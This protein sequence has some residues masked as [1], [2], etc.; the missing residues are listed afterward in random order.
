MEPQLPPNTIHLSIPRYFLKRSRS[1]TRSQVVFS[2]RQFRRNKVGSRR[3]EKL[4]NF[5]SISQ[6]LCV[7]V[8]VCVVCCVFLCLCVHISVNTC[9]YVY[10]RTYGTRHKKLYKIR[11]FT[12]PIIQSFSAAS[13]RISAES[14]KGVCEIVEG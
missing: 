6:S 14:S 8:Y 13:S 10:V 4:C 2:C 9:I 7:C 5:F 12:A 1:S 3:S 11:R